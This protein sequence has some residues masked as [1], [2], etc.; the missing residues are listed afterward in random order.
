[1]KLVYFKILKIVIIALGAIFL[2]GVVIND[3]TIES[4]AKVFGISTFVAFYF[5][6]SRRKSLFFGG[7]LIFFS[8]A[9]ISKVY[10]DFQYELFSTITNSFSIIAYLLFIFYICNTF[11]FRELLRQYWGQAIILCLISSYLLYNLNGII[12]ANEEVSYLSVRYMMES[13]Y[14]FVILALV[15]LSLLNFLY[16]DNKRSLLL[17]I[18]SIFFCLAEIVQVPYLFLSNKESLKIAFSILYFMGYYFIYL[19]ITTKFNKQY[20]ILT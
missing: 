19:Y 10:F 5:L 14:N 7:F 3:M 12:F 18:I 17:F 16:H 13:F 15:S 1:M 6:I 4:Y 9:E 20:N 11:R 8:L 2:Y